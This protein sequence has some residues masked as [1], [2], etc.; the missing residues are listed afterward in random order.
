MV[1]D[2]HATGFLGPQ[3]RGSFAHHGVKIDFLSGTFGKALGGAMGGFI[4]ASRRWSP[5]EA[6]RPAL[7]LLQRPGPGR[8][9]RLDGSHPHRGKARRAT[10]CANSCSPT[11]TA[12]A[13]R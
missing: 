2:C 1:D 3:G 6:A 12:T 7:S 13:W 4:C 10:P 5:A 11:P 8:L 9:R